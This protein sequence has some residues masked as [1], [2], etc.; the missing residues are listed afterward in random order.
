MR[1]PG[2]SPVRR[3]HAASPASPA[4]SGSFGR[5]PASSPFSSS[6]DLCGDAMT[7]SLALLPPATHPFWRSADVAEQARRVAAPRAPLRLWGTGASPRVR[8]FCGVRS[9][10]SRVWARDLG[11]Q[12]L[13]TC[14]ALEAQRAAA[15]ESV[16]TS[17]DTYKSV[18]KR[19]EGALAAERSRA[20]AASARA[21]RAEEAAAAAVA[22]AA[23]LS[24]SRGE[25]SSAATPELERLRLEV[26][27]LRASL[28]EERQ[29]ASLMADGAAALRAQLLQQGGVD[30]AAS[31]AQ[32]VPP[33]AA[34]ASELVALRCA[35]EAE[36]ARADASA[37]RE[38]AAATSALRGAAAAASDAPR[39]AELALALAAEQAKCRQLAAALNAASPPDSKSSAPGAL[40]GSER[41]GL[42]L[43][44]AP[45]SESP[46]C[47]G[48]PGLAEE[49]E[50]AEAGATPRFRVARHSAAAV[51]SPVTPGENSED[52]A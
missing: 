48:S 8:P 7:S 2:C 15:L 35:L 20:D 39:A 21:A 24:G 51:A 9:D 36:R 29:R 14:A 52:D 11:A 19:L 47:S 12:V 23:A 43:K 41:L 22:E 38:A 34:D 16:K 13:A 50:G 42:T 27:A 33:A 49:A 5:G 17:V 45:H 31:A 10:A 18:A 1:V 40:A 6:D 3:G 32:A 46:S 4:S 44:S 26:L 28:E 30:S 37:A 25:A